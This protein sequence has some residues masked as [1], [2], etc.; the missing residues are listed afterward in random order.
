MRLQSAMVALGTFIENIGKPGSY[1][2]EM[3]Q[4]VCWYRVSWHLSKQDKIGT[5]YL[6]T[7][8][9]GYDLVNIVTADYLDP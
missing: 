1:E 2:K 8:Q 9:S 4:Y 6:G 3:C 5:R 7:D